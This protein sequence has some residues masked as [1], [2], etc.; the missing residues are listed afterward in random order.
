WT[1]RIYSEIQACHPKAVIVIGETGWATRMHAEGEQGRLVKGRAAEPE[2][3]RFHRELVAW[4]AKKK[5]PVFY[6][7]AFD[8]SWKGGPHPDEIEKHWGLFHADR[9]PKLAMEKN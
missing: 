5:V 4:S 8:E 2:Q 7:V 9:R 3:Q 1:K 6:F